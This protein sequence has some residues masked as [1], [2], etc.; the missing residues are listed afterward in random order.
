MRTTLHAVSFFYHSFANRID[1]TNVAILT[2][3]TERQS[4]PIFVIGYQ[5]L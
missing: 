3:I 5:G 1:R 4:S 2:A